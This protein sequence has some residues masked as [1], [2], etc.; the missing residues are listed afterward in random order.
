MPAPYRKEPEELGRLAVP[1][2]RDLHPLEQIKHVG[3]AVRAHG[4]LLRPAVPQGHALAAY[5][6]GFRKYRALYRFLA[7]PAER[8]GGQDSRYGRYGRTR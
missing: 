3:A 5:F 6:L 8:S 1:V 7:V 2:P 4:K